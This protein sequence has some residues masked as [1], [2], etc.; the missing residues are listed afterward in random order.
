VSAGQLGVRRRCGPG[1][2]ASITAQS[3]LQTVENSSRSLAQ[4]EQG[5]ECA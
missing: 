3:R 5:G 1:F 4:F 2:T